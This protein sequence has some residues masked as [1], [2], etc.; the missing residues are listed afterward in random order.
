MRILNTHYSIFL[1]ILGCIACTPNNPHDQ[2]LYWNHG[3]SAEYVGLET[4]AGCHHEIAASFQ[5][6][7]MGQSFGRATREKSAGNWSEFHDVH[8]PS[9]GLRYR[10]FWKNDRLH[11]TEYLWDGRDT[12]HALM[13]ISTV[14]NHHGLPGHRKLAAASLL[15][16]PPLPP[17]R[18]LCWPYRPAQKQGAVQPSKLVTLSLV[19]RSI[20]L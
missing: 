12:L 6:T 5:H 10:I 7:G 14:G 2:S 15:P 1:Y 20:V 8:D 3:D 18:V 17:Y 4:C 13:M 16:P 19:L 11:V 9:T